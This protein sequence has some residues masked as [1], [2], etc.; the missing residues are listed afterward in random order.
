MFRMQQKVEALGVSMCKPIEFGRCDEGVY[1]V[2]T[3]VNGKDAE[4][5]IPFLSD[6]EMYNECLSNL[7]EQKTSLLI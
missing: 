3:W 6:L 1:T 7:M 2:Q 4:E 5:I